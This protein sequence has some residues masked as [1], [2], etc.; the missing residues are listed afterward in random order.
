MELK[1]V[2]MLLCDI[3]EVDNAVVKIGRTDDFDR[4]RKKYGEPIQTLAVIP[5]IDAKYVEKMLLKEFR[6]RFKSRRSFG[7]ITLMD[8]KDEY[9][10][11]NFNDIILCFNDIIIKLSTEDS[12]S[13]YTN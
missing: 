2:Y 13:E 1:W 11:G 5:V 4:I 7:F 10:E 3:D 8:K 12:D 9:F 6:S